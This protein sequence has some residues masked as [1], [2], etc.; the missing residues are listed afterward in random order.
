MY[1]LHTRLYS[2]YFL[3]IKKSWFVH[4][5]V[6]MQSQTNIENINQICIKIISKL[7]YILIKKCKNI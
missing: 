7:E 2:F 4:I 3:K 5:T 1:S 6:L